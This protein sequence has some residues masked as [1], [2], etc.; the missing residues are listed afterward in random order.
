MERSKHRTE[1][2]RE[3]LSAN[4]RCGQGRE[5]EREGVRPFIV[6]AY[7]KDRQSLL[8]LPLGVKR[9][10]GARV[11]RFLGGKHATFNMALWDGDFAAAA[12]LADLDALLAGLCEHG[13]ADVLALTQQPRRWQ[14][15]PTS[16]LMPRSSMWAPR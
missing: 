7:D 16:S 9:E 12:T 10:S 2:E 6:I 1:R 8:L 4:A 5:S 15:L 11:A 13:E 3:V 14:D